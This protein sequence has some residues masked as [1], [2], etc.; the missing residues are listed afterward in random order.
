MR[1]LGV[2]LF[3]GLVVVLFGP[4][5]AAAKPKP[6]DILQTRVEFCQKKIGKENVFT[7]GVGKISASCSR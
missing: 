7:P 6:P 1:K 5:Q 2:M 3:S 4:S